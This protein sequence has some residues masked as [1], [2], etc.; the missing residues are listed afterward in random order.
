M[1]R[2]F[3]QLL[4][5]LTYLSSSAF[6]QFVSFEEE[7]PCNFKSSDKQELAL[8]SS[9]YKEGSKSLE[10][11]FSPNSILDIPSESVF[12]LEGDNGITL[13][14]YNEK[15]QQD[16]LRFEFYS[17]NG[18]VS[19]HFGFRLYAAGWRACWISFK[20]MQ[21]DKQDKKI[22]GYRIIAPNRT[23]RVFI[24]RLTFPVKKIND[25]TTPDLQMPTN[26]SLTYRD[27]W[28]WCR[29]WQW[30]Q[31]QYDL[32]LSESLTTDE[33]QELATVEARLTAI[34]DTPK[35]PKKGISKAYSTFKAANI[36]PSSNGFTGA[37]VV[38]PDELNRRKGE[39]S[40]NDLEDM[41]SGFAYDA[42][43]NHSAQSAKNYFLVWDYAINQGFAFGSGMGTNHH[44]G[45]QVR[46]IYTTAWLMRDA[47]WKAPNR[48]NILSALIFWSALQ[49]TRIP[50]QYGRDELLDSWHTLLMAKTV[51]ALLFV[52]ERERARALAGLSR[53]LSGSLQYSPGTI[54]GIKV[55]GTTFHHGGFYPA[56]TTG[57]LAMVGQ[58]IAL[59][60]H[61]RYVPTMEARQVLK[62]AFISMRNYC[63]IYEWGIGISGRHPFGGSMKENDVAA[64]AYLALAGDLSGESNTFDHHLAADYI[65]LCNND[66]PEAI[67]FRKEGITPA[68]APQ[69]FFVYNYG[70]AG[71]FRR[72]D[73]MVTLKG[74]TTDVW[75][76]EIY[77]KDNRY[78]RY[79]SYGSVQIMGY[80]SR[81]A[82]GFDENGWD[83]NR[84]PGTTTIHLPFDLLDSPL[85]GTTMAH[86]KENF[87]GSSSLEGKNGMFA[88]KLME[89]N[90]KNFTPDFVARKSVF[91]FNN[92]MICLGTGISN[93]NASF[94]TET[95]LFQS[96]F[97][98]GK[99][100][101][102]V[103][104]KLKDVP[105]HQEL[106]D[107]K[108]HCIQDG[109][110]NYYLVN[111]DNVQIQIARQDS[112]HEKNRAKTQGTFAS[113]YINHGAA[114]QNA[115]YEYMVL[116][117]PS[118]KELDAARRKAPYQIL[119]KDS[120]A[121]VVID[122]QT[123]ITAYAA[124]ETYLPQK[125]EL[126]LSIPAETM[127]MQKQ[128]GSNLLLSVC[129]PNLNISEKAFT[130]KE[131]SRPIE[132]KLILK[133]QWKCKTLQKDVTVEV[134][135]TETVLTVT[136]RHGQP[137]EFILLNK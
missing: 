47:I 11:K 6:A 45:Y 122:K 22:A 117:Q 110:N 92:R 77:R 114:P 98:K 115:G 80:P 67:Y 126:F 24:D 18:H 70:S 61:T 19:H 14:I 4:F 28:H 73:W 43:Y 59:T 75:G 7:I 49:E 102:Y 118:P 90:L 60:S 108:R 107:G 13:W 131:P 104:G 125:D 130:T 111:G 41:L 8:S 46:K 134:G 53:W 87:S 25:R 105:F 62:S 52:D 124:F 113:A 17:P 79:Q 63:N 83:W 119:H 3:F 135:Q 34:L 5:I 58:F 54:G 2:K 99:S 56:Y 50:F 71:I 42:Y 89:R 23:G 82:S 103:D 32:P 109:Y 35:A 72:N 94:P 81:K 95:T 136:C 66:T 85:P 78:G 16:S 44:Y 37:P 97:Q 129:D 64:F 112:H 20:H 133:G 26:N 101:I 93:S 69:G 121:H 91:C 48:D 106:N 21:G 29:V 39:L 96:T 65:R 84:L 86:S 31:Y 123:G 100:D 40:W 9:Y 127:V 36:R 30:E 55:D 120:I 38:A 51:S 10:W 74:Y 128:S 68:K 57:V 88:M 1:T 76:S 137:I 27:L 33:K 15:P 116:I 132:K 12:T